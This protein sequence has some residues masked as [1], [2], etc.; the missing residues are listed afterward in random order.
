MTTT[1]PTSALTAV[2]A[3]HYASLEAEYNAALETLVATRNER[4]T[5]GTQARIED[6]FFSA[7]RIL[8]NHYVNQAA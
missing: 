6:R 8:N 3:E 5:K 7:L 2:S 4:L 1:Q